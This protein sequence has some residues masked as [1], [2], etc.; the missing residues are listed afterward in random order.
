M[1]DAFN[2]INTL[3]SKAS[4]RVIQSEAKDLKAQFFAFIHKTI[5]F[6]AIFKQNS[7]KKETFPHIAQFIQHS[8]KKLQLTRDEIVRVTGMCSD[9]ASAV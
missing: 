2:T 7:M 4:L 3:L 6:V 8:C 1:Q 5:I 9:K